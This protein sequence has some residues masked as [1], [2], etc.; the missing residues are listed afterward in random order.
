MREALNAADESVAEIVRLV[1]RIT[2]RPRAGFSARASS[3][4]SLYVIERHWQV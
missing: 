2:E 1:S 4:K 3:S